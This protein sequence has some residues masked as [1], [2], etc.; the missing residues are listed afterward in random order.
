MNCAR[1]HKEISTGVVKY[2]GN[3]Y[4][5]SCAAIAANEGQTA[6]PYPARG[7]DHQEEIY[8]RTDDRNT[9]GSRGGAESDEGRTLD[10]ADALIH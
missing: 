3:S 10:P 6:D 9:D 8:E 1:C 4:H 2:R 7:D 5:A